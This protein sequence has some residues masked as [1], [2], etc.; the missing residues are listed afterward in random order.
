MTVLL[1]ACNLEARLSLT[2]AHTRV[3]GGHLPARCPHQSLREERCVS[4]Q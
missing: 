2:A 1:S 4:D 3:S